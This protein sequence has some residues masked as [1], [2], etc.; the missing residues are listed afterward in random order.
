MENDRFSDFR[1]GHDNLI[2]QTSVDAVDVGT[3]EST[4]QKCKRTQC[5]PHGWHHYEKRKV[6]CSSMAPSPKKTKLV[7]RWVRTGF[8]GLGL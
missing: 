1:W 6:W 8:S 2:S 5:E 4:H 7:N 3:T